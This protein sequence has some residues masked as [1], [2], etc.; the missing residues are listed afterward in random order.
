MIGGEK[1]LIEESISNWY[2]IT[3]HKS[4]VGRFILDVSN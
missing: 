4:Y 3:T 2:F 1:Y